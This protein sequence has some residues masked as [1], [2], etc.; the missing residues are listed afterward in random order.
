MLKLN[1]KDKANETKSV[2]DRENLAKELQIGTG[3][4]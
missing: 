4:R 2:M 3:D 1:Q